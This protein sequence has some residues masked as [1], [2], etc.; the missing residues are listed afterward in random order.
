M[1]VVKDGG[2]VE[3]MMQYEGVAFPAIPS[4]LHATWVVQD[5]VGASVGVAPLPDLVQRKHDTARCAYRHVR[6]LRVWTMC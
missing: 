3:N 6:R 1:W 2:G 5:R 4:D